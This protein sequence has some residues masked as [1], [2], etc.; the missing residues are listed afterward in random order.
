[1]LNGYEP[2]E[3]TD[4]DPEEIF[5]DFRNLSLPELGNSFLEQLV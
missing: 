1:M 4:I 3:D 5:G 2:Y